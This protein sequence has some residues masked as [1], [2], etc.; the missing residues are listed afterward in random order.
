MCITGCTDVSRLA[1]GSKLASS[2]PG[3]KMLTLSH[4]VT[5]LFS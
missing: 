5:S 2:W 4:L 3:V 1:G